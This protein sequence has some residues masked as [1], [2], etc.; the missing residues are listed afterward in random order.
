MRSA[1]LQHPAHQRIGDLD[2]QITHGIF[3]AAATG[4]QIQLAGFRIEQHQRAFFRLRQIHGGGDHQ[5]QNL[6]DVKQGRDG[7][8]HGVERIE[9]LRLLIGLL[10]QL[11]AFLQRAAAP[12]PA[13]HGRGHLPRLK[14][15]RQHIRRA[16]RQRRFPDFQSALGR[17]DQR[18]HIQFIFSHQG[19]FVGE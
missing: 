12:H 10:A 7:L 13:R 4:A 16:M 11:G 15:T 9:F 8:A 18:R 3:M 6:F 19:Q 17:D 5:F 2:P 1:A 14:R